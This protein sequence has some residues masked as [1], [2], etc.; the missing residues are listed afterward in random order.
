[1]TTTTNSTII[2]IITRA[3]NSPY[4][5]NYDVIML[6]YITGLACVKSSDTTLQ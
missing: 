4:K 1:M 3:L 2:I 5:H 6:V